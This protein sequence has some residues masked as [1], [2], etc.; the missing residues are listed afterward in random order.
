ML[1]VGG[2]C[3]RGKLLFPLGL[4]IVLAGLFVASRAMWQVDSLEREGGGG[5]SRWAEW[6][7]SGLAI[8]GLLA[9][10][11]V[12]GLTYDLLKR[13]YFLVGLLAVTFRLHRPSSGRSV[14]SLLMTAASLIHLAGPIMVPDPGIDNWAWTQSSLQALIEGRHPYRLA[15]S[16]ILHGAFYE[17]RSAAVYPYMPLTLLAGLPVYWLFGE[18][19]F[20]GAVCFPATLLLVGAL[21]RR[22]HVPGDLTD[23]VRL[24]LLLHPRG[25]SLT[26]LGWLEPVMAFLLVAY[27]YLALRAPGGL[28]P[29]VV[30][31]TMPAWKQYFVAPVML[32]LV[33]RRR[34]TMHALLVGLALSV[35]TVMPFLIWDGRAT[36]RGMLAVLSE[37]DAP[38]LDSTSLVA[39]M[40][41]VFGQYPG[42]W[43][44]AVLQV[45]VGVFAYHRLRHTGV[46][47]LLLASALAL[48]ATFLSAWQAFVNYFEVVA[49]LLALASMFLAARKPENESSAP[50]SV[51]F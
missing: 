30:F 12:G 4:P 13:G 3:I 16:D 48:L 32:F 50:V 38:R 2:S 27:A 20:L 41:V 44:S 28:A 9:P 15:T 5:A 23:S 51:A 43:L 1:V 35:A 40:A 34:T 36:T 10:T 19:R 21:G 6:A 46:A 39:L 24:L 18:Y 45:A 42:R 22:L 29:A 47:G 14:M 31:L 26:C 11:T 7:L 33:G 25:F 17:G 49:V 8:V 37:A